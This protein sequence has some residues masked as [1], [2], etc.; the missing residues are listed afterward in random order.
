MQ[1]TKYFDEFFIYYQ[2]LTI[3]LILH[4]PYSSTWFQRRFISLQLRKSSTDG[5]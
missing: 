1:P 5:I 4:K 2:S 3:I